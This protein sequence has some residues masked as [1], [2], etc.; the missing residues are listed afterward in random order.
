MDKSTTKERTVS[1]TGPNED[2]LTDR[3]SD[4]FEQTLKDIGFFDEVREGQDS[5]DSE[6]GPLELE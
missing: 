6:Q 5:E 1:P 3:F 2:L 4:A